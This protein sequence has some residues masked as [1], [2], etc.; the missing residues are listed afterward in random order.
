MARAPAACPQ[1]A[2]NRPL[3]TRRSHSLPPTTHNA[4]KSPPTT[5]RRARCQTSRLRRAACSAPTVS[6]QRVPCAVSHGGMS[7]GCKLRL[8]LTLRWPLAMA[9]LACHCQAPCDPQPAPTRPPCS[10][11]RLAVQQMVGAPAK[12]GHVEGCNPARLPLLWPWEQGRAAAPKPAARPPHA[13]LPGRPPAARRPPACPPARTPPSPQHRRAEPVHAVRQPYLC[14]P[15]VQ[16]LPGGHVS[17]RLKQ[18]L[19]WVFSGGRR[20]RRRRGLGCARGEP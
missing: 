12:G 5:A 14:G 1:T 15:R 19:R 7:T 3:I 13:L 18:R 6:S 9:L 10:A 2:F 16:Q 4:A 17:Q 8:G 20:A 11:V